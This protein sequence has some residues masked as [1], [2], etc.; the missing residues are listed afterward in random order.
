MSNDRLTCPN[1]TVE[2]ESSALGKQTI[3]AEAQWHTKSGLF[4]LQSNQFRFLGG[5][6]RRRRSQQESMQDLKINF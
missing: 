5:R 3:K 2:F 6:L 4:S 1:A